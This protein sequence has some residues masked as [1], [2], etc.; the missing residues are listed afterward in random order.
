MRYHTVEVCEGLLIDTRMT[1]REFIKHHH[2]F[3]TD[4]KS[5]GGFP[6]YYSSIRGRELDGIYDWY[7]T[8][9]SKDHQKLRKIELVKAGHNHVT[10]WEGN[11]KWGIF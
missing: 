1:G 4:D 9:W 11:K 2:C 8:T 10:I 5:A 6:Q 7:V 3:S